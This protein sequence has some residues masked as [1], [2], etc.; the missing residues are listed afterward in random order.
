MP[1]TYRP[2]E[3]P[4][5]RI[6]FP[7]Q[8]FVTQ[9]LALREKP[10]GAVEVLPDSPRTRFYVTVLTKKEVPELTDTADPANAF[11][12]VWSKSV[13]GEQGQDLFRA[14]TIGEQAMEYSRDVLKQ[15]RTEAKLKIE[16][17][18]NRERR[19]EGEPVE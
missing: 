10:V 8:D 13:P 16:A 3:L 12:T 2:Y 5:G 9:L 17:P 14:V 1:R 11:S 18:A 6:P 7:T 15:L 19:G 4:A